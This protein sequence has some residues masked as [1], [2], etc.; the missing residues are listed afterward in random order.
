MMHTF[1]VKTSTGQ[2]SVL[3]GSGLR[4]EVGGW[5]CEHGFAN[6]K[7]FVITDAH[8][9]DCGYLDDVRSSLAKASLASADTIVPAGDA[10]KSLKQAEALYRQLLAAGMRRSD[11]IIALGGGVV[12]DLAGFAAATFLRGIAYVQMPTT[13]LA[14]DSSVGGKVGINL[15]EGKNLVGAF[16]PPKAVI[17][18]TD[19]LISLPDREWR[20]GMA[21]VVKHGLIGNAALFDNLACTPVPAYPG[22]DRAA[23]MIAEAVQVKIAIVEQDEHESDLRM[24]LNVGHTIGHAIEKLSNYALGHG[25]AIAI[26]IT[27]EANIARRLGHLTAADEQRIVSTLA[28][29]GLPTKV[30][31]F[32]TADVFRVLDVDKKHSGQGWTFALPFGIGDVRVVRSVPAD[33]AAAALDSCG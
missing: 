21:E 8:V 14:H 11:L 23:A 5:L 18:D 25:E 12:G 22:A 6:R 32:E 19:C 26:G 33:V 27:V 16:H 1:D 10:S 15:D 30:P 17:Y 28:K 13:L 4:H 2:Y 29:Q 3:I 20:N 24:V 9:A 7:V 31:A